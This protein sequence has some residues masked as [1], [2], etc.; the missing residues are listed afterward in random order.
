MSEEY[1]P[2]DPMR[3]A[4]KNMRPVALARFYETASV[5]PAAGGFALQLDGRG[6]RTPAKKALVFP[7]QASAEL[8]AR[9]WAGQG[10]TINPADMPVTRIANSAID[11]VAAAIAETRAE[12][13]A[14]AETDLLYYRAGAPEKLVAAQAAAYDP[15]LDWVHEA[16]GAR[17]MLAEGVIHL[18]QPERSLNAIRQALEGI[19]E[20]FALAALHVMTTLTG[21]VLLALGVF[22]GVLSASDAWRIA[23]VDEDFQISQWGEDDEAMARRAA[24]WREMEAAAATAGALRG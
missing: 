7:T 16:Y 2:G 9:E 4:Q 12:L 19:N 1:S 11:G 8:A 14:Y 18:R 22:R 6:A 3:A 15:V 21:S 13:A 20:P 23:N 17:F 5:A 24:R 10:A